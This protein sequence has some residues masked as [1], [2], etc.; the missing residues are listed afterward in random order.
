M[1]KGKTQVFAA[2]PPVVKRAIGLDIH[3]EDLGGYQQHSRTSGVVNNEAEDELDALQQIRRFLS[4]LP[5][6][7]WELPP[8][9][10]ES[11]PRDRKAHELR[12]IIPRDRNRG[13]NPRQLIAFVMDKDST[14]ELSRYCLLYTSDA[15][16]E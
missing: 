12:S 1:V 2:G 13:Y 5:T 15:A 4:Y 9:G 11:D 7:V 14:F 16:D 6:N 3:K 8:L 10:D